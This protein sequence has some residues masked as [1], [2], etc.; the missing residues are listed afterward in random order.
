MCPGEGANLH[1]PKGQNK[2]NSESIKKV[3]NQAVEQLVEALEAGRSE[4]LTKY[5]AA[6]A[7]FRAYSFLNVLL[8]LKASPSASRVAGY[9]TWQ[10]FGRQVKQGE[11]GIMILAPMFRKREPN[12]NESD[13]SE[14]ARRVAGFRAVYV[15]DRLS[16]DLWPSLCTLD[17]IRE[18]HFRKSPR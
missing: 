16:R 5:L 11:K 4:A 3:T 10:S 7:K 13:N 8:I 15:W 17:G 6:M 18:C 2:M 12:T 14:E 9:K 1:T